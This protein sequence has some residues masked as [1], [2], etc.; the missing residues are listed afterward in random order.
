MH[1]HNFIGCILFDD[2]KMN[3][4]FRDNSIFEKNFIVGLGTLFQERYNFFFFGFENK[5]YG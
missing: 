2:S 4:Y 5:K 3:A 1:L